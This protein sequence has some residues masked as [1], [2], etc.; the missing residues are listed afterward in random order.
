MQIHEIITERKKSRKRVG[1][2]NV[3]PL[4]EGGRS[5]LVERMK[6]SRGKKAFSSKKI[7]VTF[8]KL[9][10][11][12]ENGEKVSLETLL[13]KKI[14]SKKTFSFG[15]KIVATGTLTKKLSISE[16]VLLSSSAQ[17]AIEKLGGVVEEIGEKK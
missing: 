9:E 1:R 13:A 17:E 10:K 14:L 8:A 6:K 3:D 11:S 2:G 16:D 7:T 5:S 12:F 4:F 15:A